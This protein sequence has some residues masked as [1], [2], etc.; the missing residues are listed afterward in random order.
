MHD[1]NVLA[2]LV[3]QNERVGILFCLCE[4]YGLSISSIANQNICQSGH[5]ILEWALD[6][7]VIHT[8]CCLVFQ[9]LG[10]I[11]NFETFLHV[12][13]GKTL[14]PTWNSGREKTNL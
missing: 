1:L 14:D 8:L 10:E 5:P 6:G 11:N 12:L 9:I 13:A 7:Q 3:R 4:H 2:D